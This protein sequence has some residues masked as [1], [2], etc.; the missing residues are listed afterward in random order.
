MR[1][2]TRAEDHFACEREIS[3]DCYLGSRCQDVL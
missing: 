1:K 2:V 3:L